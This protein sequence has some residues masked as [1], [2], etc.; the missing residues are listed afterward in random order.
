MLFILDIMKN[1]KHIK[2]YDPDRFGERLVFFYK[3]GLKNN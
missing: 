1:D 2:I 3:V